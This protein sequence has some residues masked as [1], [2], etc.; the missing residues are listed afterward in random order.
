VLAYLNNDVL[1]VSAA[2]DTRIEARDQ[3]F[4]GLH[5]RLTFSRAASSAARNPCKIE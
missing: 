1:S 4:Q 2:T 3:H 5:S